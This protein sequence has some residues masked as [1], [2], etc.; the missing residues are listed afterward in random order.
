MK[1][2]LK[3]LYFILIILS[4]ISCEKVIEVDLDDSEPKLVIEATLLEGDNECKVVI[5]KSAPYFDSSPIEKIDNATVTLYFEGNELVIPNVEP[6]E[7]R[8]QVD[9]EADVEYKLEV[10]VEGNLYT[11]FSYM[12]QSIPI[13][14]IYAIYEEGFGPFESGYTVYVMLSDP[15]GI[16]NYYRFTHYLNGEYQNEADDLLVLDDNLNDGSQPMIP[17]RQQAFEEGDMVEVNLIHFDEAS[18]DYFRTLGDII[19]SGMG[20]NS[21]S[22]APGNPISNWSNNALGYFSAYSYSSAS[23]EISSASKE[24]E[25]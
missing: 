23:I 7:Y 8:L 24:I 6:G 19:G 17:L 25:D 11:A 20:P 16:A 18:Y 15:A 14:S 4:A 5:S 21:G 12:P 2:L 9:A 1:Y 13:D 3:S 22:A 10:E